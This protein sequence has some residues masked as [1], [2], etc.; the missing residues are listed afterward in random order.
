MISSNNTRIKRAIETEE[1]E[2]EDKG[3]MRTRGNTYWYV[4]LTV[5]FGAFGNTF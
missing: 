1:P 3:K 5:C 4:R 2:R